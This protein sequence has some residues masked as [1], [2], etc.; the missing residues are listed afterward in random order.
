MTDYASEMAKIFGGA[1]S[2]ENTDWTK[3]RYFDSTSDC[4]GS[5]VALLNSL[6]AEAYNTYGFKVQ[7]FIKE[8]NYSLE[9]N[10]I[11]KEIQIDKKRIHI[12]GEVSRTAREQSA[13]LVHVGSTPMLASNFK[14]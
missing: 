13:K 3:E 6:T 2:V 10:I 5:E 12:F 11:T 9:F 8:M 14:I 4:Y 7:Y 1:C